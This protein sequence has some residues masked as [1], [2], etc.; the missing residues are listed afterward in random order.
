[1]TMHFVQVSKFLQSVIILDSGASCEARQISCELQL[2]IAYQRGS[3]KHLLDWI[4]MSLAVFGT[5]NS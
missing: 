2:L 3:L 4:N 5:F 1:M